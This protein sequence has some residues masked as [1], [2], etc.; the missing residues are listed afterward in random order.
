MGNY[1]FSTTLP[2]G[3]YTINSVDDFLFLQENTVRSTV[4]VSPGLFDFSSNFLVDTDGVNIV[5]LDGNRSIIFSGDGTIDVSANDCFIKGVDVVDK[6]FIIGDNL[7]TLTVENCKGGDYSFTGTE[8]GLPFNPIVI[9]GTFINCEGGY[10][11]FGYIYDTVSGTFTNCKVITGF[12]YQCEASGIFDSCKAI[13]YGS[14]GTDGIA[15]GTFTN[16]IGSN[17]GF[18]GNGTL[19]GKLYYCRLIANTFNTVSGGGITRLCLDGFNT[20][21]NQG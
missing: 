18:G 9:S 10:N 13:E 16:C 14:F 6:K 19:T 20:E 7:S 2:V 5:S 8:S 3:T 12:G 4:I 21:N 17:G 15:S 11:S 1:T